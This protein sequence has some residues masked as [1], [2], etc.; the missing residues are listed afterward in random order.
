LRDDESFEAALQASE[1]GHLV[2]G[3]MH[4]SSAGQSITRMLD[5]FPTERHHQ[6]R[7]LLQFN[8]K[9]VIV[10]KLVRGTTKEA[11]LL[12]AVEV[13]FSNPTIRKLIREGDEEKIIDVIQAS[14]ELGMQ[15]MNQ[16]LEMLVASGLITEKSALEASPNPEALRMTL[17]G[18]RF[19]SDR[20]GIVG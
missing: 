20:G 7:T 14:R 3:A 12:P 2:L 4:A 17:S 1:T 13:M 8:L 5:L 19:Q 10:Q 11:P 9:A 18:I 15:T 16:S 6:I